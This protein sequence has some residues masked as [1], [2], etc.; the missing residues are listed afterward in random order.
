[1]HVVDIS[2]ILNSYSLASPHADG[3]RDDIGC[4]HGL[5]S[6]TCRSLP[7]VRHSHLP[8]SRVCPSV[9]FHSKSCAKEK[10]EAEKRT[11][12]MYGVTA[13]RWRVEILDMVARNGFIKMTKGQ[14]EVKRAG[15]VDISRKS[16][17]KASSKALRCSYVQCFW[18][19]VRE[20]MVAGE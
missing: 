16:L 1:M 9:L 4:Q 14:R 6:L 10:S 5:S 2:L 15:L 12:D 19:T 8:R 18:G 11:M 17:F 20:V 3:A 7:A 13:W